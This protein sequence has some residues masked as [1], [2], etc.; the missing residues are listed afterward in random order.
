MKQWVKLLLQGVSRTSTYKMES[1]DLYS[2]QFLLSLCVHMCEHAVIRGHPLW[3]IRRCSLG[4]IP[5]GFGLF[6][7]GRVSHYPAAHYVV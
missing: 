5:F 3:N 6:F 7:S 4:A 2:L 1:G